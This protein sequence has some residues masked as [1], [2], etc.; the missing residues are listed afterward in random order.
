MARFD[1]I[2]KSAIGM[3]NIWIQLKMQL[4][5]YTSMKGQAHDKAVSL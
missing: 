1:F 5:F 2:Q 3:V 4:H